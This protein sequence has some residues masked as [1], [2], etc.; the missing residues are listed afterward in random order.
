MYGIYANIGGILMINVT[1]Y[2][3]HG[4]TMFHGKI[5][6]KLPFSTISMAIFNSYFDITRGYPMIFP[7]YWDILNYHILYII[8]YIYYPIIAYMDPMGMIFPS[9]PCLSKL[10]KIRPNG[11]TGFGESQWLAGIRQI[12]QWFGHDTHDAILFPRVMSEVF[13]FFSGKKTM[14]HLYHH[15]ITYRITYVFAILI[16]YNHCTVSHDELILRMI[17]QL[18]LGS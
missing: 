18:C 5:H 16:T 13:F 14:S 4:S 9:Y 1:I 3:I 7:S 11:F 12:H 17:N 15:Y 2:S 10:P 8:I 6:Y